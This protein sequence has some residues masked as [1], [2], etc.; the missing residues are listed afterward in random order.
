MNTAIVYLPSTSVHHRP[1]F[2]RGDQQTR[3]FAEH[4]SKG[5]PNG[6]VSIAYGPNVD[7]QALVEAIRHLEARL[8]TL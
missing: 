8:L 5:I 4:S 6:A 7:A 1:T 2:E 3:L